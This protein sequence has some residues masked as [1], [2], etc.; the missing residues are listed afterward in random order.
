VGEL[1]KL[2]YIALIN[3]GMN[4]IEALRRRAL[5]NAEFLNMAYIEFEGNLSYFEKIIRGPY[6]PRNFSICNRV[7]RSPRLYIF[8]LF[9]C[10]C[11]RKF[12]YPYRFFF[13][14]GDDEDQFLL[15]DESIH[16]GSRTV[17]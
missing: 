8:S 10:L 1:E 13:L 2:T 11:K 7:R 14:R 12:P 15:P 17:F 4:K 6:K 9:S 3:S 5:E 16:I